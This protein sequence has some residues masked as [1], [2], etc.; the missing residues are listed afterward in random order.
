MKA[1]KIIKC[2][3]LCCG[4]KSSVAVDFEQWLKYRECKDTSVFDEPL[5][6]RE[7]IGGT[8][9]QCQQEALRDCYA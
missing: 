2:T 1:I 9:I 7:L 4:K 5:E 6:I 8:C 3:C